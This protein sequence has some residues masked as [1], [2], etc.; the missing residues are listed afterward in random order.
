MSILDKMFIGLDFKWSSEGLKVSRAFET[1]DKQIVQVG[2]FQGEM[3]K[4]KKGERRP[5]SLGEVAAYNEF[6]TSRI[7]P[8]PFMGK[9]MEKNYDNIREEMKTASANI[10][11]GGDAMMQLNRLG[12]K[13]KSMVQTSIRDGGW[14]PNAPATVKKK[15]SSRPL[16]DTGQMWQSV[17]HRVKEKG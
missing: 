17:H 9:A 5:A 7:P 16:I 11:K 3:R 14:T 6:G 1:L 12:E 13:G 15:G 4:P 10:T 2:F 8:R